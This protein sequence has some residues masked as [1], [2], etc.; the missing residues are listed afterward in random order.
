MAGDKAALLGQ[1]Q[2]DWQRYWD[3]EA[4]HRLGF[5]RGKCRNCGKWFWSTAQQE[6][7]NDSSCRPYEFIDNP[8]MPKKWD[9]FSA[10]D[11]IQ[12]FFVKEGH[13]PLER[14]P[15][16]ARWFP[17][18]NF[19]I[20]GIVD[21]YR[22]DESKFV[23]EFP[24]GVDKAILL[25]PSLRF[26]D[27]PQVGVSG[28]HWTTHGHVEQ[29]SLFDP[30]NKTGYWKDKCIELDYRMLTEVFGIKPDR[31]NW[32]EDAWLGAG[33]F[34]YSLEYFAGGL[35]MG[36]AVFT[37]FEGTPDNFR[38]MPKKVID[39]GAGLERFVWASQRTPT[40]YD[41][42]LGPVIEKM[43]AKG[44]ISYDKEFFSRYSRLSGMLNLDE[45]GDIAKVRE[46]IAKKLGTDTE[47]MLRKTEPMQAIYAIADHARTL[48]TAIA[49][50]GIPSNIGGGYNLRVLLRRALSFIDRH[51]LGFDLI[52][53]AGQVSEYFKPLYPEMLA[54]MDRFTEVIQAE[55]KRYR[56]SME[57]AKKYVETVLEKKEKLTDSRLVE[58]YDTQGI[59]PELMEEVAEQKGIRVEIPG[60]FWTKVTKLHEKEAQQKGKFKLD[61]SGI[62]KTEPLYYGD[63]RTFEAKVLKVI[64]D[65]FVVLDRTAFYPR[66][67]GQE[68]DHGTIGG[69]KV[70]DVEKVDGVIVHAAESP[71]FKEGSTVKGAIDRTR[72]EQ[73]T[74]NHDAT[75]IVN[76]AARRV[77][78]PWVWQAG[79]KKDADKAHLD[80]THYASL[81]P[82][83]VEKIEKLA[84]DT[85]A[86][87][88]KIEKLVLPRPE[89]E[90]KF[91][92]GIYQG[93]AVPAKN[94]RILSIGNFD[95]EACGGTH[96]DNTA[97][98][99]PI[100]ITKTERP[101]DGTVRLIFRAGPAAEK[102][103]E[104]SGRTL[105]KAAG[106]LKTSEARVPKAAEELLE[107]WKEANKELETLRG[108][109]AEK[110]ISNLHLTKKDGLR[111]LVEHVPGA[112]AEQLREI[113]RKL[114][115]EDTVI[116]LIGTTDKAYL[117]GS[118]GARAGN[119]NTGQLVARLAAELGGRG[120][121]TP[122]L[123]QGAA[124]DKKEADKT[125]Q[126]LRKELLK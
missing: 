118:A 77:L 34:G 33:A 121:G 11:A 58:L 36:N 112:N 114:S 115:A 35:E 63:V 14:Y 40:V 9:Y 4:L 78:G 88:L 45:V 32:I 82:E 59:T 25:Q 44:G 56:G 117:F 93:A 43:I 108:K 24:P 42:V 84:N 1:L 123:A 52:W 98:L 126:K 61:V 109:A 29:A 57:S 7:C 107:K 51:R 30:V 105:K 27:I 19:T 38:V 94:L 113:S 103:L 50:G 85:A 64:E 15:V 124:P 91:G 62:P 65:K 96:G 92:F 5:K 125:I 39:M 66:G 46:E 95:T 120:G 75:H 83:Q 17:N 41:A 122:I 79:S 111:W 60:D 22:M 28:R 26:N 54:N 76:G 67:G 10:W 102:Y 110:R 69:K 47:T 104:E 53:V 20:A 71:H 80:I 3:L 49:D 90:K 13:T 6:L 73:I 48:V 8:L 18:L 74:I 97:D 31:I 86:K 89:A 2:R 37:E 55:E 106:L 101:A 81:T 23:F 87:K 116:I 16:M 119:V 12:K 21:F 70:Y 100:V 68:P 72:R 99:V